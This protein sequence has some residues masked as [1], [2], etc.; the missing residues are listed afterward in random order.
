MPVQR[1]ARIL[2]HQAWIPNVQVH[3]LDDKKHWL[4]E[5]KTW[6]MLI[7]PPKNTT[8]IHFQHYLHDQHCLLRRANVGLGRPHANNAH[9]APG[10]SVRCQICQSPTAGETGGHADG[11]PLLSHTSVSLRLDGGQDDLSLTNIDHLAWAHNVPLIVIFPV[12]LKVRDAT[13]STVLAGNR[14]FHI[15]TR[16]VP[17]LCS[18][19]FSSLGLTRLSHFGSRWQNLTPTMSDNSD[20]SLSLDSDNPNHN[21]RNDLLNLCHAQRAGDRIQANLEVEELGRLGLSCY[22]ALACLC[23]THAPASGVRRAVMYD[24]LS[25]GNLSYHT[26]IHVDF[27]FDRQ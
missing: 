16:H 6:R 1:V 8:R 22:Y 25:S 20:E 27:W 9:R 13:R 10:N 23:A 24:S 17:W 18:L 5:I 15:S 2:L 3:A 7:R 12:K 26:R 14:A 21:T 11:L 19:S 4:T